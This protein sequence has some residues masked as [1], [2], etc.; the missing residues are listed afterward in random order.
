[1]STKKTPI[2]KRAAKPVA[3]AHKTKP[4][5]TDVKEQVNEAIAKARASSHEM[6][7]VGLGA[8]AKARKVREER[9]KDLIAEGKRL[10]PK[11]MQ[12]I[13]YNVGCGRLKT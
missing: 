3:T 1:M 6:L 7:L 12:A 13:I 8:V 5:K 10:E 11:F 4:T 2:A 9:R